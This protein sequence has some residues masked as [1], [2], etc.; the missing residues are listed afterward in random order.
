MLFLE[1][2]GV[3]DQLKNK[4]KKNGTG[5]QSENS[6]LKMGERKLQLLV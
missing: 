1:F 5:Y 4:N 3:T 6:G 2:A